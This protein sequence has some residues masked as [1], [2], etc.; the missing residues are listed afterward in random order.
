[1]SVQTQAVTLQVAPPLVITTTTL[2][3]ATQGNPYSFKFSATGGIP[4]YAW[5]ITSGTIPGGMSFGSDGTLSG[6]PLNSGSFNFTV[7]VTDSGA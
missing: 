3:E 1:M 4:P 2:P 5:L 6:T 7:Q